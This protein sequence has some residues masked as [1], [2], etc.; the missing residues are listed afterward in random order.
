M[1]ND[2]SD[3]DFDDIL[4]TDSEDNGIQVTLKQSDNEKEDTI[5]I[6]K[7]QKSLSRESI[8]QDEVPEQIET[9]FDSLNV[10]VLYNA[11]DSFIE[12]FH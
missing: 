8:A 11:L 2:S 1:S 9:R 3:I 6:E 4:S 12:T 10:E 5:Q 7:P